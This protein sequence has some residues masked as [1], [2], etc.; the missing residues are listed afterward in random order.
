L[1]TEMYGF[2]SIYI[3]TGPRSQYQSLTPSPTRTEISGRFSWVAPIMFPE[4]SCS[5]V[6][7]P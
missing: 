7:Q 4:F 5:S 2:L 6:A 3:L 1:F